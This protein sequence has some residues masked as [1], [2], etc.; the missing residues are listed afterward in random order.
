MRVSSKAERVRNDMPNHNRYVPAYHPKSLNWRY[1]VN[2]IK[3]QN[4]SDGMVMPRLRLNDAEKHAFMS[5]YTHCSIALCTD[6]IFLEKIE[7]ANVTPKFVIYHIVAMGEQ[8]IN[9][10]FNNRDFIYFLID[11][12]ECQECIV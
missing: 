4:A 3:W 9:A 6:P 12:H 8:Y 7:E 11:N 10:V 2:A 1:V 5:I